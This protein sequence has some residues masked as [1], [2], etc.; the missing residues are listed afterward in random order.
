MCEGRKTEP[1]YLRKF[2]HDNKHPLVKLETVDGVGTPKTLVDR[3][4]KEK[5][6]LI[7]IA[8]QSGNS[9]ENEYEVWCLSDRDEHP[10]IN[11][12]LQRAEDN[13]ISYALSNPCIELWGYLHY[14]QNDAPTHRGQMQKMLQ[15]VMPG[16]DHNKGAVFNYEHMKAGYT[17]AVLRASELRRRRYEEDLVN[18]NPSTN[19]DELMES[20]RTT[21]IDA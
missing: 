8:K 10:R 14:Q 1:D 17:D 6:K 3:A 15:A 5:E 13:Q 9:F 20:I 11:E 2:A 4:I 12:E 7:K 18:G 16:Y 21:K 19:I